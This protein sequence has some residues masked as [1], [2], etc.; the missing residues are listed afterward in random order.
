M[1]WEHKILKLLIDDV[2]GISDDDE[3]HVTATDHQRRRK[4]YGISERKLEKDE[5][6][7]KQ[8]KKANV[9]IE[10]RHLKHHIQPFM[11]DCRLHNSYLPFF[12]FLL[13]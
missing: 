12:P 8:K 6:G 13:G 4:E 5:S 11:G 9:L 2:V 7:A 10:V 1:K 3:E